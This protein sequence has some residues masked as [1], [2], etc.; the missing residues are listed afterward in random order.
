MSVKTVDVK[1]TS[2]EDAFEQAGLAWI[3][4]QSE[5]LNIATNKVITDR[6]VIYRSDNQAQIGVVGSKYGVI[7]NSDCFSFFNIICQKNNATICKVREYFGGSIIHLEAEVRDKKFDA[8]IGDEVGFRFNLWN[9]FD[10]LHKASVTFGAL[11]LVCTNGLVMLGK[12]SAMVEIRHTK[13]AVNR[14]NQAIEVWSGGEKWYKE[15]EENVKI[16]NNKLVNKKIVDKFLDDLFGNSDSA[17]NQRK[18]DNVIDLFEHGKGNKGETAWDLVNGVTEYVDHFSKKE[19]EDTLIYSMVG[20]G[21]NV[22]ANAFNL[23][24]SI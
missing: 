23:A 22:K 16:L 2:I 8:K 13:N 14:M 24:M 18:K 3:A 9:S 4:E 1:A 7:Q 10:G 17:V 21:Y 19:T 11:R 20:A 15:F 6:K 12:D 5:M